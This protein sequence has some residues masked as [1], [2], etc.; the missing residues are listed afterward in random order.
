MEDHDNKLIS[1]LQ[2]NRK[3]KDELDEQQQTIVDKLG[4]L[5]LTDINL[6]KQ[7]QESY[8][9][10]K[11][12]VYPDD[13]IKREKVHEFYTKR[14]KKHKAKMKP[15]DGEGDGDNEE[16]NEDEENWDNS[17]DEEDENDVDK[18]DIGAIE[19]DPKVK[20]VITN[21]VD[22]EDKLDMNKKT[23]TELE[24]QKT[25]VL[26]KLQ[27][28]DHILDGVEREIRDYQLE[29]LHKTNKLE[30][31]TFLK[32]SQIQNLDKT[33]VLFLYRHI[34]YNYIIVIYLILREIIMPCL[35]RCIK[36]FFSLKL[37]CRS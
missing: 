31:A 7:K 23:K 14:F 25:Q 18:P 37:S 24:K 30:V 26:H 10:F 13:D 27:E 29:K 12:L 21:I 15:D 4:E 19:N 22:L 34:C 36:A 11:E 1:N 9:S 33:T 20:E 28:I 3:D 5:N 6:D 17:E 32:L 2:N 16:D 35:T 8:K